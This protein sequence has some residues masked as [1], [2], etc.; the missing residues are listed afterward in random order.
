MREPSL[1]GDKRRIA[2]RAAVGLAAPLVLAA[3]LVLVA[4][5]NLYPWLK[6][7]HVVAVIGWIGGM[8]AVLYLFVW[9]TRAGEGSPQAQLLSALEGQILQRI[10]N[11]AMVITWGVGLWLAWD[12]AWFS[13]G[14]LQAKIAVVVVLS[15]VHGWVVRAAR[16]FAAGADGRGAQFYVVANLAGAVLAITAIILAVVKP[17]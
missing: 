16:T 8:L 17:M 11:P 4:A 12:G 7:L 15:A 14:W 1:A 9:H 10:V 6:A 3:T 2:V 5:P 13:S